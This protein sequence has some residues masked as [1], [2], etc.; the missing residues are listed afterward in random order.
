MIEYTIKD[1]DIKQLGSFYYHDKTVFRVFAPDHNKMFLLIDNDLYEMHRNHYY[2]EIALGGDLELIRYNY[3]TEDGIKF[4]DPFAYVS[5]D[6]KSVVVNKNHFNNRIVRPSYMKNIIIYE[7]N[8]RDFSSSFSYTGKLRSKFLS[9]CE[10][11]LKLENYYMIGLDYL[12]NLGI[13]HLQLMPVF[14]YDN[15]GSEYNWG[16]N[17]IAY[18]YVKKDYVLDSKEPY[19]YINELR[20]MVNTLHENDIRVVLDVVF[21]HV[22]HPISNDLGIML[23]KR[24]FRYREDG[25]LAEGTLCG[26]EINSQDVFVR[27]YII[28]MVS[29]Y[30]ELFDIDGIRMDLMGISDIDTVNKLRETMV[31]IKNDFVVYGEG[32]NMGD[33]LPE[34]LRASI[35]NYRYLPEIGMF[36]DRFR[37]VIIK[38]VSGDNSI[39]EE[40][41]QILACDPNYLDS[42]HSINYVECHD[43]YTMIDHMYKYLGDH[44]YNNKR[45][46]LLA[47]SLI[48]ISRGIPFIHMGQE[49]FRT[50]K[51]IR[52]TYSCDDSINGIDWNLR[53]DNNEA[54]DYFKDLINFRKEHE[55]FDSEEA[56]IDFDD[57]Y[58]CLIYNI[59]GLK[60]IINASEHDHIYNDG[61]NNHVIFNYQGRCDFVSSVIN[62]PAFSI[63]VCK[64]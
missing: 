63:L 42:K 33:V 60:I 21:N 17:P 25:T 50:K 41:K 44:D 18:N 48:M 20:E 15:D 12:K 13:T 56:C 16:Y 59:G 54:T 19:A 58:G 30:I 7:A 6:D 32:W 51:G 47:L 5:I 3:V 61:N 52:N 35:R 9:F 55:I 62:I 2:F 49:F 10:S 37:D 28:E 31:S 1:F 23:P 4:K 24:F 64:I 27:E 11:G 8:V 22:Y 14:D 53:V 45:R 29:R 43:G 39:K 34:D 26:N 46:C 57:Y 40:V 36:N 38:Y